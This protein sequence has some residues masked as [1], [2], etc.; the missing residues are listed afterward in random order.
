MLLLLLIFCIIIIIIIIIIICI[1]RSS[2]GPRHYYAAKKRFKFEGT[3]THE[4][5][6][7][8]VEVIIIIII[9]INNI[10]II[11]IIIIIILI[12]IIIII[13]FSFP[14]V[15]SNAATWPAVKKNC[16][17]VCARPADSGREKGRDYKTCPRFLSRFFSNPFPLLR[18]LSSSS[19]L[20]CQFSFIP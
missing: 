7:L 15:G 11:I 18:S 3:C 10:I 8:K 17:L 12:I 19:P 20:S 9:I 6:V 16:C 1:S 5:Y 4:V 13:N 2:E 14:N